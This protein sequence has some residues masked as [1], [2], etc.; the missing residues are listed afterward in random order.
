MVYHSA[1]LLGSLVWVIHQQAQQE[2][3]LCDPELVYCE[4]LMYVKMNPSPFRH[5]VWTPYWCMHLR[6]LLGDC[7][8]GGV[9]ANLDQ[10]KGHTHSQNLNCNSKSAICSSV[11][12]GS[13]IV[14]STGS[15]V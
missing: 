6:A 12:L 15:F 1:A 9:V 14:V 10:H 8:D 5:W 4:R 3:C 7:W 11:R 13:E 2:V